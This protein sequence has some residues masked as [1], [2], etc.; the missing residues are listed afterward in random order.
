MVHHAKDCCVNDSLTLSN[1]QYNAYMGVCLSMIPHYH[2]L[3]IGVITNKS[4]GLS[5]RSHSFY[6][7]ETMWK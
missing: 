2:W 1:F 6:S 3:V 5:L 7:D 4:V